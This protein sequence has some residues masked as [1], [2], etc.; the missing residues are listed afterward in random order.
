LQNFRAAAYG[1][2][3]QFAYDKRMALN[4]G[5]MKKRDEPWLG[6]AQ[7]LYPDRGINKHQRLAIAT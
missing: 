4:V 2:T 1:T 6:M 3:G 5:S 7:M